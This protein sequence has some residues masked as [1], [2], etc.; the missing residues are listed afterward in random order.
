MELPMGQYV[1]EP[2]EYTIDFSKLRNKSDVMLTQKLVAEISPN[3]EL[4]MFTL[5]DKDYITHDGRYLFSLRRL[6]MDVYADPTEYS[7][8]MGLFGS[9]RHWQKFQKCLGNYLQDWRDELE[10]KVK[11]TALKSISEKSDFNSL[12]YLADKGWDKPSAGK[13]SKK[14]VEREAKIMA[15]MENELKDD[16]KRIMN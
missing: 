9:W 14:Q 16:L 5:K 2:K 11:S 15:G 8:A 12:K 4:N 1:D 7:F 10:I 13:P 3:R 6:Y